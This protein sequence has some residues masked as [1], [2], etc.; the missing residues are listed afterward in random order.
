MENF[1]REE[2]LRWARSVVSD[3]EFAPEESWANNEDILFQDSCGCYSEYTTEPCSLSIW[4]KGTLRGE[5]F[6]Q[7]REIEDLIQ[8]WA[9]GA[10]TW[11]GCECCG[12]D[13][14]VNVNL[15]AKK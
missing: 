15:F 3:A 7:R 4:L 14:F 9:E 11:G 2:I 12:N 10:L 13:L 6:K 1:G 8:K 5:G